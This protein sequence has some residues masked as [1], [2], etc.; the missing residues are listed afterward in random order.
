MLSKLLV[1][2]ISSIAFVGIVVAQNTKNA[3]PKPKF[4]E[5]QASAIIKYGNQLVGFYNRNSVIKRNMEATRNTYED[6]K[7]TKQRSADFGVAYMGCNSFDITSRNNSLPIAPANYPDKSVIQTFNSCAE[8]Y[9]KL[10]MNCEAIQKSFENKT[11]LSDNFAK[12]DAWMN[13]MEN[14]AD[15][16]YILMR[17]GVTKA[18]KLSNEAEMVFLQKSPVKHL[19]IPMKSDL[20]AFKDILDELEMWNAINAAEQKQKIASLKDIYE[21]NSII[22]GKDFSKKDIYYKTD[23]YPKFYQSLLDGVAALEKYVKLLEED[24]NAT[25]KNDDDED[26]RIRIRNSHY[27]SVFSYYNSAVDRYNTFVR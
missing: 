2:V 16:I 6:N 11:F 18:S 17:Q 8:L 1:C 26:E 24:K 20:N 10:K 21:K 25:T 12:C 27:S 22:E 7:K 3:G 19:I 13:A 5:P 14:E 15:S 4:T 23:V 9:K